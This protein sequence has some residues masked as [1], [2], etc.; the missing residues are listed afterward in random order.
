VSAVAATIAGVMSRVVGTVAAIE[1]AAGAAAVLALDERA[2]ARPT[3]FAA[4]IHRRTHHETY[5]AAWAALT[6]RQVSDLA[7]A[8]A[9]AVARLEKAARQE[10]HG[11]GCFG[12][13]CL[14]AS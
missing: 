7:A 6:V 8:A 9:A 3:V 2:A 11:I 13:C 5:G 10:A 12:V 14:G 1:C 4:V